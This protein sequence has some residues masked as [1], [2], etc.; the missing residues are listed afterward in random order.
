MSFL[1]FSPMKYQQMGQQNM[2]LFFFSYVRT[3][4]VCFIR[5]R[6]SFILILMILIYFHMH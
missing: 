6:Q 2:A 5:F 1:L 4:K 3:Y